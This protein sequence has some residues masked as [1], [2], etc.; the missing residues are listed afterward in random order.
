MNTVHLPQSACLC[1][2]ARADI[3]PPAGI[4]HRMWG[5]AT[6]DRATG[7]HRPLTATALWLEPPDDD[8]ASRL[9]VLALDHCILDS[10][11]I[12]KI[13][14]AAAAAVSLDIT[15]VL[16]TLSHTHGSGWMSQSRSHFPG[17]ELIGPYLDRTAATCAD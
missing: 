17:G 12:A 4:Y 14:S 7:V 13:R 11:E 2:V 5:A 15:A 1:G 8:P 10:T 3:T 9:L 16:V 6:H